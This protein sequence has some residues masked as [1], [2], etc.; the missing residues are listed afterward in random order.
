MLDAFAVEAQTR[1]QWSF[2]M[3]RS[4]VCFV[5]CLA[6]CAPA[7]AQV[8]TS[9]LGKLKLDPANPIAEQIMPTDK[10]WGGGQTILPLASAPHAGRARFKASVERKLHGSEWDVGPA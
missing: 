2:K 5:M 1:H 7:R 3:C 4:A 8:M 6:A 9:Q 10:G